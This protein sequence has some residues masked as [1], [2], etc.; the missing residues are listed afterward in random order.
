[1][2]FC[3]LRRIHDDPLLTIDNNVI[4]VVREAKFLGILFDNKLSF[5]PHLRNLRAKCMKALNLGYE[6]LLFIEIGGGDFLTLIFQIVSNVLSAQK[7]DYGCIVFGLS[8]EIVHSDARSYSEPISKTLF[9]RFQNNS[10]L[11]SLQ[12]EANEPPLAA[13]EKQTRPAVCDESLFKP[14]K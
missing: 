8:E 9:G 12:V 1:M 3:N 5:I 13:K 14:K 7:L 2:H 11:E 6:S 4:P 10:L